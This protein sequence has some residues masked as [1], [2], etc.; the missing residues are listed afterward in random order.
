[1]IEL[2]IEFPDRE[3]LRAFADWLCNSGEQTY[4]DCLGHD[5]QDKPMVA[6]EY[7]AQDETKDRNDPDRYG[8]YLPNNT[9]K[10]RMLHDE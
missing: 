7:H 3:T 1:M 10:T 4:W 5:G 2:K 9:I 8:A 6:F